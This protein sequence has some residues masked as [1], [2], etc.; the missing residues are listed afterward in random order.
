MPD[1]PTLAL[2]K[3]HLEHLALKIPSTNDLH[4]FQPLAQI[5]LLKLQS[6]DELQAI[7]SA[8]V[9]ASFFMQASTSVVEGNN[10]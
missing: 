9:S 7:L 4:F 1:A 10:Y 3:P 6:Y 2:L 5:V 8:A